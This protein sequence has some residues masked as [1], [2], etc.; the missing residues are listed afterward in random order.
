MNLTMKQLD[1]PP[2]WLVAA[3]ALAWAQGRYSS[4]GLEFGE[5]FG[6][7]GGGLLIGGGLLLILLAVVEMRRMRTTVHPHGVPS[8]LVQ[9]GIFSRSRNPIYLG[10]L[11]V[12]AGFILR[13][14]A[15]LSLPL[16]P[17]FAWILE[18]RFIEA[19]ETHLRR[20]F[21]QDWARYEKKV[22]RWL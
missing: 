19:E 21:R 2:F 7:L 11:L 1:L 20:S 18:K 3:I 9:S 13:F 22:R 10:D 8:H 5:V 15:V 12:L 14:D 6:G 4:F 16:I 17:V